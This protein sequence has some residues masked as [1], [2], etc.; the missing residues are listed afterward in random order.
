VYSDITMP[1]RS[2]NV[3]F[4][5]TATVL[6]SGRR[7][8]FRYRLSGVDE[9]WQDARDRRQAFYTNLGPG[10]YH[11]QVIASNE[12]GVWNRTGAAVGLT[13]LPAWY[14]TALFR[15]LCAVAAIAV[16]F[17]L[18]RLRLA[19]MRN[20]LQA[21][22][23]ERL[24]E[25]ERIARELHDTLIQGFQGL[26]LVFG[27]AAQRLSAQDPTRELLGKALKTADGVLAQGRDRV[28]GLRESITLTHDLPTALKEAAEDLSLA[29]PIE[30]SMSVR[31]TQQP[32]HS[33]AMEE[34]YQIARAA[35]TN[36]HRHAGA[37]RIELELSFAP[38]QLRLLVRD[39]G[40]GIDEAVLRD[41][42]IPGHW[43]MAGM[44]ERAKK[45]GAALHV[46]SGPRS[47]TEVDL[48]VPGAVAYRKEAIKPRWWIRLSRRVRGGNEYQ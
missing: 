20:H 21:R 33:V 18:F 28:R 19:Q 32:L 8:Q 7:A 9:D 26:V 30:F 31:G 29:Q 2:S 13:I 46:R 40:R 47:G 38:S 37:N 27:A 16:L 5:Y 44:R 25:R 6:T 43:G 45:L 24:I 11:F 3:R 14:Q 39:D 35:L 23:Q 42:G 36:A 22:L 48:Q 4:D 15:V 12:N 10:H 41:G 34:A 17:L 1:P